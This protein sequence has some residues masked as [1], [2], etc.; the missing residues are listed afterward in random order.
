MNTATSSPAATSNPISKKILWVSALW[1]VAML[2]PWSIT[3]FHNI[4][5]ANAWAT[6]PSS[7]VQYAVN[8]FM[9]FLMGIGSAIAIVMFFCQID[10]VWQ[11]KSSADD[12]T[13]KFLGSVLAV[14]ALTLSPLIFRSD[15]VG[16]ATTLIEVVRAS[17]A[18]Q[19]FPPAMTADVRRM[20]QDYRA[21]AENKQG[22]EALSGLSANSSDVI[23]ALA[24]IEVV[25]K[26]HP[27]S[28]FVLDN[29]LVRPQDLKNL[30]QA[31]LEKV[32]S[33][34]P[35]ASQAIALLATLGSR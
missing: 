12:I 20:T 23:L 14:A 26:E 5:L 27:A 15:N 24:I 17:E 9:V 31:M 1:V 10:K 3:F 28:Q 34:D 35:Q 21:V 30:R 11:A 13:Y 4:L 18:A 33:G 16:K 6:N 8:L 22:I 7:L 32:R 19:G 2:N 29:G 25:G